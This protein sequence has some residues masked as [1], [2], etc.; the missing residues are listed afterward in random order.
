MILRNTISQKLKAYEVTS[1]YVYS[2]K[3]EFHGLLR[4]VHIECS[5]QFKWNLY[6]YVS[7][8]SRPFLGSAKTALKFKYE[9]WIG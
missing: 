3:I 7:G 8:Q 5:K 1:S 2:L 6:F 9:I 4:D